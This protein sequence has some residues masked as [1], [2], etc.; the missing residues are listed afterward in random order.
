[1]FEIGKLLGEPCELGG[2]DRFYWKRSHP[3]PPA[4]LILGRPSHR[5]HLAWSQTIGPHQ[6]R[7]VRKYT[8]RVRARRAA[9]QVQHEEYQRLK[10][11]AIARILRW[12]GAKWPHRRWELEILLF[13]SRLNQTSDRSRVPNIAFFCLRLPSAVEVQ[14]PPSPARKQVPRRYIGTKARYHDWEFRHPN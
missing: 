4:L 9:R 7:E 2:C 8:R 11:S 3:H 6:R 5:E 12:E 14:P 10:R 1:M 13:Q